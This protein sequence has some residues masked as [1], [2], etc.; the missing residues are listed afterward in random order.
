MN[1]DDT[2]H[3]ILRRHPFFDGLTDDRLDRIAACTSTALFDPGQ[4]IFR[5]G[6]DADT[7][8]IIQRG[9]VA[10]EVM[11]PGQGKVTLQSLHEG[12]PLGWSW[13][14]APF[15]WTFDAR[16][17]APVTALAF[18]AKALQAVMDADHELAYH[19]LKHIIAIM[20]E[21]LHAARMQMLDLYA[22][23]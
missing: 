8:Y 10:L 23:S 2:L 7:F 1:T 15:R 14:T 20:A 21:R 11:N 12:D 9:T 6:G 22:P 4:T 5:E 16:A 13:I 17:I 18:D 3:D 19:L